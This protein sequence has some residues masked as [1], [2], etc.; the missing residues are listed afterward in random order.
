MQF[1]R[2]GEIEFRNKENSLLVRN[3][4]ILIVTNVWCIEKKGEDIIFTKNLP[5]RWKLLISIGEENN[6]TSRPA[7]EVERIALIAVRT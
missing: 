6:S 7:I 2:E 5:L 4:K 3:I 1:I